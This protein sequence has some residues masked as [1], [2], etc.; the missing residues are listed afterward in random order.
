MRNSYL[1][2]SFAEKTSSSQSALSHADFRVAIRPDMTGRILLQAI[3][4][5]IDNFCIG[6]TSMVSVQATKG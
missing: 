5:A 2:D 3:R 4:L 6:F 1:L